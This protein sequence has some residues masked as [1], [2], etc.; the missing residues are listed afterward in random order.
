MGYFLTA[1]IENAVPANSLASP[2]THTPVPRVEERGR[3]FYSPEVGKWL[4]RDPIEE[5]GAFT[6]SQVDPDATVSRQLPRIAFDGP[7]RNPYDF[8]CQDPVNTVDIIG[9]ASM[10]PECGRECARGGAYTWNCRPFSEAGYVKEYD[11]PG[12]RDAQ[13][14]CF[15]PCKEREGWSLATSWSLVANPIPPCPSDHPWPFARVIPPPPYPGHP[16]LTASPGRGEICFWIPWRTWY[17]YPNGRDATRRVKL[18]GWCRRC[19]CGPH[20]INPII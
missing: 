10:P 2:K 19:E 8:S 14:L 6:L 5:V 7:L 17:V 4:S 18:E 20:L 3:R 13:W 16:G 1:E 15:F 12:E 11:L 9:L